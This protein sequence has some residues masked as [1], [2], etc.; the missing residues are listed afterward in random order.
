MCVTCVT[1]TRD[2]P[3]VASAGLVSSNDGDDSNVP[4]S[5][6][7]KMFFLPHSRVGFVYFDC[8]CI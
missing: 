2:L 8:T 5:K 3:S 4:A 1:A 7:I 6:L